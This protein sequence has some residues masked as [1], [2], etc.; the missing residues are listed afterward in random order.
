M[1][2][3]KSQLLCSV[4]K[5]F[6]FGF[7]VNT[8]ICCQG[9]NSC[10]WYQKD[11]NLLP[12]VLVPFKDNLL[13]IGVRTFLPFI[14]NNT[15]LVCKRKHYSIQRHPHS[16]PLAKWSSSSVCFLASVVLLPKGWHE[17][18]FTPNTGYSKLAFEDILLLIPQF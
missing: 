10:R 2:I 16:V 14:L 11:T 17:E 7:L 1:C 12:W 15:E 8:L 18:R 9:F 4:H 5:Q 3:T 6:S 13:T